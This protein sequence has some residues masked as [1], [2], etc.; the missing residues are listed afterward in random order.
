M[1][2]TA[3]RVALCALCGYEFNLH[4]DFALLR[5]LYGVAHQ[6]GQYLPQPA[7]VAVDMTRN[8]HMNMAGEF[9]PLFVRTVGEQFRNLMH[10]VVK[11]ERDTFQL[12]LACLYFRE[13]EDIV[14]NPK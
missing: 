3:L 13:I 7:G 9:E 2:R 5:K 6:I 12:Q 11:A 4:D 10:D 8:I 1:Q 14:D